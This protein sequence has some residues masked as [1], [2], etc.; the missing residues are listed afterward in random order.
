LDPEAARLRK[1]NKTESLDAALK[2]LNQF[3]H[4]E[5]GIVP[6]HRV[7]VISA[8]MIASLGVHDTTGGTLVKPLVDDDLYGGSGNSADGAIILSRVED[9]LRQR[10]PKLPLDKQQSVLNALRPTLLDSSL[11]AKT[12]NGMSPLKA[13]FHI[14]SHGLLPHYHDD[15]AIDFAG[16]LFN[17]MYAWIDVPDSGAN[18]VVLTPKRTTELMVELTR[19]NSDS[20]VWDWTLGTGAFLVSAMNVM[21]ADARERYQGEALR[22]KEHQIK[23]E[24]LL[25]IEKLGSIYV[26]AV[27][28]MILMGDGSSNIIHLDAHTYDG[29]YQER[30]GREREYFPATNLVL[31]PPYSAPGNGLIFVKEAFAMMN[32]RHTGQFG[33]VIIQDSAGS[34]KAV[35]YCRD[36]LKG[37]TL[38]ASIKMPP[39][40]FIGKSGVQTSIYV[41]RVGTPHPVDHLVKFIDFRNDGY[42]RSNRRRVK[43]PSINLRPVDDPDGRYAEVAAIVTGRKRD[44]NYYPE[45]ELYF[46]DTIDPA[47]GNDWNFDQH[48]KIDTK[49]TLNDFRKTVADYLTWEVDQLLARG[50]FPKGD[51]QSI[52]GDLEALADKYRIDWREFNL[53]RLFGKSTRGRRLRS[54]DRIP[55]QLPF[56]TAGETDHGISAWISNGVHVFSPN[57]ITI[58][59][60][61]SAKYRQY[62]YGADDHVAVVHTEN[63]SHGAAKYV[64]AAIHKSSHSSGFDY[65]R[66]FYAKD[67]DALIIQL[68]VLADGSLA[69]GYM[70]DVVRVLED[71]WV[72]SLKAEKA[73]TLSAYRE[74]TGM[75]DFTLTEQ[76]KAAL[77]DLETRPF[78]SFLVGGQGGLF[79]ISPTRP[80]ERASAA[81]TLC[82]VVSNTSQS[83]G[84]RDYAMVRPNNPANRITFSDTTDSVYTV[85]YQPAPFAGY[86]HVQAMTPEAYRLTPASAFFF[87][88]AFRR[89]IGTRF[90]WGA[91]FNR[92]IAAGLQVS[93]PA[94]PDGSPDYAFMEVF[95]GAVRKIVVNGLVDQFDERIEA[96]EYVVA[97][98]R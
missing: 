46:E 24:Q 74:A 59:M 80:V 27:L 10:S 58:D 76:E 84:I 45:N 71:E 5:H 98:G 18:D 91:K 56:V 6:S 8:L 44:T 49:P 39:D 50:D 43:D 3:L 53:E 25:G 54:S 93:L 19:I 33:A 97:A 61:G 11:S 57:T 82:P 68:P 79:S 23:V 86:A 29:M 14:V 75:S 38:E 65:S 51:S 70:E 26:L 20:Y 7:N 92:R 89:A 94:T 69:W 35:E 96:S 15:R 55:G 47:A 36:I 9:Y 30:E 87:I 40:L 85:F 32:A 22:K 60:F 83:N 67:A 17:E 48:V 63:L 1:A 72:H 64:T 21:M 78:S 16:K 28:N 90:N 2:R 66:N 42:K 31:N 88:A 13:A 52:H 34:G 37:A 4:D 95:I 81:S 73:R 62:E 77:K 41:F 12:K